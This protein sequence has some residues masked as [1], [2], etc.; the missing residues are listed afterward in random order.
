MGDGAGALHGVGTATITDLWRGRVTSLR[1]LGADIE[2]VL[3]PD[4]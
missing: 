1:M 3:E 4:R 2:V